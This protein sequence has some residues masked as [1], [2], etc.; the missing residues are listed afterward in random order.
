M[1]RSEAP[2]AF[3]AP[4]GPSGIV[5][6]PREYSRHELPHSPLVAFYEVTRACD[7]V[8]RH[9]RA[10]AQAVPDPGELSTA[11]ARQLIDQLA[12][13]PRPPMLVLT[14]GDPLKR[15]DLLPLVAH[16]AGIGLEVA[17]TPSATPLVTAAA[18]R[19]LRDAGVAR[20]AVSLDG[21]DAATHDAMRG[22]AGSF[23]RTLEILDDARACGLPRQVNTTLAP[24]NLEQIDDM[25]AL[26]G[27]A[28]AVLWSVFFLVPVGRAA[29]GVRLSADQCEAAFGR[30]FDHARRQ[31]FAI[32]TSEAPHYRRYVVQQS[33]SR[34]GDATCRWPSGRRVPLGINDGKG[35]MFISHVGLIHPSGFLPL[36]CG[37]FPLDHVVDVYRRSP[38]FRALRDADRLSGKCGRCE[39]RTI[40]GGSRAR[41]Y[42]TAGDPFASEPDCAYLPPDLPLESRPS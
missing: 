39:Y 36:F 26:V 2:A 14:G 15:A 33:R 38:L 35:V 9:C 41:A 23:A 22:V 31:P 30:L 32:K 11:L 13:F 34:G 20:L 37:L 10:C 19:R 24:H 25:A 7:L 42:A 17:V 4:N 12:E 28:G 27:R 29:G 18:I 16:A 3:G 21:A 40:C 5:R 6:A 1:D 8:C